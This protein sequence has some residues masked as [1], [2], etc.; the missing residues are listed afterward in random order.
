MVERGNGS[1]E[2]GTEKGR[3]TRVINTVPTYREFESVLFLLLIVSSS[4]GLLLPEV[5]RLNDVRHMHLQM[6]THVST[7]VYICHSASHVDTTTDMN[8]S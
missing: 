1:R 2:G 6:M 5:A 4:G 7:L 8:N 3:S